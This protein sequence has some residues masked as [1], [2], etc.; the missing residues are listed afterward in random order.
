MGGGK[1]D[2][3]F[4]YRA[5]IELSIFSAVVNVLLLVMPLYLLQVYDRVLPSSSTTTLGYLSIIAAVALA[6]LAVLEIVRAQYGN[7]V[8]ARLDTQF[9]SS[10]FQA[11]MNSPRAALGD[12]QPLRDLATIRAFIASRTLFFLFDLP[13]TPLFI[14]LLYLVHPVLFWL[15]LGG[16]VLLVL[17]ALANQI[18][19]ARATKNANEALVGAMNSAQSFARNFETVRALGMSGST[20]SVWGQKFA[21]ALRASERV[22][23]SNAIWGGLSRSLRIALQLATLGFGALL[24][25]EGEMTAGMIFASTIISGRALQPLDQMIGGWRQIIEA[26]AAWQRV[27]A[28]NSQVEAKAVDT[29]TLPAPEGALSVEQLIYFPPG[30][31]AGAQPLIKRI[32]FKVNAGEAVAIIGPSQAG[33]STLARLIVG[34]IRPRSGAVRVDGSDIQNFE[35]DEL[36]RHIGYLPQ[37]VELFPGTIAQNIARFDAEARDDDIV[38]AAM[39]AHAHQL[40]IGQA[41]SYATEIGPMGV[42]LSGGERQRIGLARAFYGDPKLLVLD[43]PNANLD[44]EG[45]QALEKAM[46]EAKANKVTVL[47][48]THK[49]SIAA[50]CDRVMMLRDGQIELYGPSADVLQRLAQGAQQQ[51]RPQP[52]QPAAGAPAQ[53]AAAAPVVRMTANQDR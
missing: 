16:A 49:P 22:S 51:Q 30:A 2:V 7:R 47:I 9:G 32:S 40:V 11:A 6:V 29:V 24:V 52:G 3:K 10:V 25:L 13:F 4:L 20:M 33:K 41:K 12:V 19:T 45:E 1:P 50:K 14:A 35:A 34:A 39:R 27:R 31:D 46:L 17:V 21:E 38:R 53:P 48:I 5:V 37:E 15:T 23:S 42:R 26:R 28:A 36:G 8:A 43:E 18:A 44:S